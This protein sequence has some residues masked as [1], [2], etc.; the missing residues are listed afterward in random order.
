MPTYIASFEHE[1]T[2]YYFDYSTVVDAPVS[3]LMTRAEYE[4]YYRRRWCR[5]GMQ[6]L[7]ARLARTDV[8]G[9]SAMATETFDELVGCNRAGPNDKR[10]TV[11][12]FL[13]LASVAHAQ[14][15]KRAARVG[16]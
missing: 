1:G 3:E 10:L 14:A 12:E 15:M 9:S 13:A 4:G 2:R 5:R 7:P 8:T 16:R 6:E 11:G